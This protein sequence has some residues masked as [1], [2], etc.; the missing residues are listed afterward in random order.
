M[1]EM[2]AES[3]MAAAGVRE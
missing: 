3:V 2:R 1:R